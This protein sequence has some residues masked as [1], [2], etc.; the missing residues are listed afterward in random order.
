MTAG[1]GGHLC[2]DLSPAAG[3]GLPV[4]RGA[5]LDRKG[6]GSVSALAAIPLGELLLGVLFPSPR[7][8][9]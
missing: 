7:K 4:G 8:W 3:A 1:D 5:V 2:A 6:L 9:A